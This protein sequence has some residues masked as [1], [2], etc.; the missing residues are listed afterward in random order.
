SLPAPSTSA[1]P[2]ASTVPA[3]SAAAAGS[4]SGAPD[5]KGQ[6]IKV[7]LGAGSPHVSDSETY[8]M[9]QML[10]KWGA[11]ADMQL[12]SGNTPTMAVVS[13]QEDVSAQGF[14]EMVNA[15]L[16]VFG[17][18]QPH[19]DYVMISKKLTSVDQLPGK[20]FGLGG[21]KNGVDAVLLHSILTAHKIPF[22]KVQELEIGTVSNAVNAML[23]GKL[24]AAFIHGDGLAKVQDQGFNVL[25]EANKEVPWYGDSFVAAKSEW[26][27]AHPDLAAAVD[28]AYLAAAKEFNTDTKQWVADAQS[29]TQHSTSDQSVTAAHDLFKTFNLWPQDAT[30]YGTD[31]LQKNWDAANTMQ[32]IKGRGQRPIDQLSD[33][34]AWQTAV[35]AMLH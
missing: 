2:A 6:T 7:D 28:E 20:V 5:L 32:D 19:V 11:T 35:K 31:S 3:A 8:I 23:G 34:T 16:T 10:K 13:G 18:N 21:T 24:D 9:V 15:G 22:D 14:S 26:I 25:A 4:A 17:P 33:A 12:G 30:A 27:K 1:K 29:Y